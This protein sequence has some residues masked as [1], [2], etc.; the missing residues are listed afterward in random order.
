[1]FCQISL[2]TPDFKRFPGFA[3]YHLGSGGWFL[4]MLSTV[5]GSFGVLLACLLVGSNFLTSLA[6]PLFGGNILLYTLIY[7]FVSGLF[8]FLGIKIIK[9]VELYVIALLIVAILFVFIEGLSHIKI[10][11]IFTGDLEIIF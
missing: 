1:M 2:K 9:R 7:F 3:K 6:L 5:V 4:A 8:V 11:N 10:S